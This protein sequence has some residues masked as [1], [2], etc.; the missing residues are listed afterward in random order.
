MV[1]STIFWIHLV[2]GV[3]TGL[4]VLMMSVTGVILTYERQKEYARLKQAAR[5]L[6]TTYAGLYREE[7]IFA[8]YANA[9]RQTGSWGPA[10]SLLN[11]SAQC[12]RASSADGSGSTN[13][14]PFTTGR[15]S[16]SPPN[17]SP[18]RPIT[19]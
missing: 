5:V 13:C 17:R 10:G 18:S 9:M 2:C 8:P 19:S 3:A 16:A 14:P 6:R 12:R 7:D 1:R 4:V 15:S 11:D